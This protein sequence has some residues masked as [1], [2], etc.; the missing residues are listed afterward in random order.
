MPTRVL[1]CGVSRVLLSPSSRKVTL[2]PGLEAETRYALRIEVT[3][4]LAQ[5]ASPL[6][7][8]SYS[9]ETSELFDGYR[10]WLFGEVSLALD[11]WLPEQVV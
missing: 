2:S 9:G 11:F 4:P 5:P 6:W 8:I 1:S 10:L 3:N 7:T